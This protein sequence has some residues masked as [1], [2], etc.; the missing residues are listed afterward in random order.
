M[1]SYCPTNRGYR[2]ALRAVMCCAA[3][4]WQAAC[5]RVPAA[6]STPKELMRMESAPPLAS[7]ETP[8]A[9]L[10]EGGDSATR[11]EFRN[12][13]FHM[14][15]D[16]V[17][18]IR[19]LRGA[20]VATSSGQP[21]VFDNKSSFVIDID[22]AQVGL[23]PT[24]LEHL[25]NGYVFAYRGAPLRKLRFSVDGEKLVQS[26]IMHKV[27][28]IPFQITAALSITPEGR[29]RIHPTAIQIFDVDGM[30][31]MKAL[32]ITL[33]RL[34][35]LRK[36][37]GVTV[38]GNDLLLKPDSL[39]PPPAIAG[40]VVAVRVAGGEVVQVF[41]DSPRASANNQ[42]PL[43][44]LD[45]SAANY[46]RFMGGTLRFGKLFMVQADMQ[47]ID[48]DPR[49]PFDFSIDDYNRQLVAGYSKNTP[50]GGLKVYMPDLE[51]ALTTGFRGQGSGGKGTD[52]GQGAARGAERSTLR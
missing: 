43:A 38:D 49:D 35:D 11:A 28:D 8:H 39:L 31:L 45:S 25:M 41:G 14:T 21:V 46:M 18:R 19:Y 26:G 34:L 16:V 30:G 52:R 48:S 50:A 24:N 33:D 23:T 22:S 1:V 27:V 3:V 6:D 51:D 9:V 36:A 40:R 17:L 13:Y 20:M 32:G 5:T 4:L 29:I 15:P 7:A 37:K 47:I 42:R 44:P 12:V 10:A 2:R